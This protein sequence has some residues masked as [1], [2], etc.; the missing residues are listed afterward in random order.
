M[1]DN[2]AR[3]PKPPLGDLKT[4]DYMEQYKAYLADLGNIG[5][6]YA[7]VQGFYM[8]VIS[9]LLGLL[10][11]TDSTKE[12]QKLF[13][14]LP[15]PTLIVVCVFSS[16]LCVVWS[17]TISFYLKLFGAKISVLK[18]LEEYLPVACFE[19]EY[20]KLTETKAGRNPQLPSL[21][22]VEKY[23]PFVLIVFF[24]A[25]AG[26]RLYGGRKDMMP[27]MASNLVMSE[28]VGLVIAAAIA[29]FV[30]F[31]TLIIT[32]EQTVSEFRQKW[33]DA[34]REDI[35]DVVTGAK[36]MHGESITTHE[37]L[38]D[39][40]KSDYKGFHEATVK[41]KLRLNPT[42][43]RTGEDEAT[44]SVLESLSKVEAIFE[45][46]RPKFQD[47]PP[48]TVRIVSDTQTILKKNWERVKEGETVYKWT[49]R[50]LGVVVTAGF[51]ACVAAL[52][53]YLVR[54]IRG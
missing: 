38:W 1:P 34:L 17:L 7:T 39:K 48:L 5:T 46:Q 41:V 19:L 12:G 13:G 51:V 53:V 3:V 50:V 47:L 10:A 22:R 49:K 14:T 26:I 29:G 33:I 27:W 37:A 44:K 4:S 43:S 8:S 36:S 45:D 28:G 24:V 2:R 52:V 32:K 42:E 40:L 20:K 16:L 21:L 18:Q 31:V 9:A 23:V 15:A 11:L 25:L 35:A 6:R 30:G 54:A